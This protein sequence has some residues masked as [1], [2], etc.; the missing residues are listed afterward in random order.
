M[1]HRPEQ[2]EAVGQFPRRPDDSGAWRVTTEPVIEPRPV[3]YGVVLACAA[4]LI[5]LLACAGGAGWW[6]ANY[7]TEVPVWHG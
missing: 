4:G 3:A 2:I 6:L 5:G 1:R 7:L